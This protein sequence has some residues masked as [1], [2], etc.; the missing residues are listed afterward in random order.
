[1]STIRPD[2]QRASRSSAAA[3]ERLETCTRTDVAELFDTLGDAG[4][5]LGSLLEDLGDITEAARRI[6]TVNGVQI[7]EMV[8]NLTETSAHL[9]TAAR[10]IRRRPWRLLVP[11]K[12]ADPRVEGIAGAAE[13]FAQGAG[14]L[15]AAIARL[16]ALRRAQPEGL[17]P[18]DPQLELIR[19]QIRD[20]YERFGRLEEALWEEIAE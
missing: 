6:V 8:A 5:R 9:K 17:A 4:E 19:R 11:P 14:E 16:E 20:A 13:A 1:M 10:D 18:D 15:D 7:D 2:L 3:A 12:Q